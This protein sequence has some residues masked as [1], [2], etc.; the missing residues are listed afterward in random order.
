MFC[1]GADGNSCG[2]CL[3]SNT[4]SDIDAGCKCSPSFSGCPLTETPRFS[5]T[6]ISVFTCC[7]QFKYQILIHCQWEWHSGSDPDQWIVNVNRW[8]KLANNNIRHVPCIYSL[9]MTW[10]AQDLD[11][12]T[13]VTCLMKSNCMWYGMKMTKC[14]K[15]LTN[16]RKSDPPSSLIVS[17]PTS[18]VCDTC[19]CFSLM[20]KCF[21]PCL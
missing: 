4:V 11:Q 7:F 15:N 5:L 2:N 16:K 1:M 12:M 6:N 17:L 13:R 18:R 10:L 20:E 9:W 19:W 21:W 8:V 3:C 14:L